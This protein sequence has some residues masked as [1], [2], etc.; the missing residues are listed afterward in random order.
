MNVRN[1]LLVIALHLTLPGFVL[2]QSSPARLSE[3]EVIHGETAVEWPAVAPDVNLLVTVSGPEGLYLRQEQPAGTWAR[4][5]LVNKQ[6]QARPDG[7]YK[8]ELVIQSGW[9]DGGQGTYSGWFEIQGGRVAM[10]GSGE[11]QPVTLEEQAPENSLYI[12]SEGRVGVGTSVPG[13]LLHLK[14]K[15][16]ALAIEDTQAGG[17]EY[18]MRSAI[19]GDGSLGLFDQATGQARWLVDGEGRVGIGTMEPTSTLTVDGYIESTKGFLVNGRPIGGGGF[20]LSG[21]ANPLSG[22]IVGTNSFFGT[23]A[24]ATGSGMQNSFFGYRAGMVNSA[25]GNSF[26]GSDA[27]LANTTGNFNAFFGSMTG[28]SSSTGSEN[29]FF[30]HAAGQLNTTGG[31]NS[32]FGASAGISNT[33]GKNNCFFGLSSGWNNRTGESNSFYGYL[34]GQGNGTGSYNSFYGYSAGE[35]NNASYN[36]FFGSAAGGHNTTGFRNSFFGPYAG[37]SNHTG[38]YNSFFGNQAGY[39]NTGSSNSYF[40]SA[41]GI[42]NST[43]NYGAFFGA[44]S[45]LAN[46][47]GS[48][49]SFFGYTAGLN[50]TSGA[51]NSFFG[52]EAGAAN[53]VESN[54][55]FLGAEANLGPG[56]DPAAHPVTNA[57]AIGY[58][59][60]VSRSN[61]LV[62]GAVNGFNQATTETNVGIGTPNP[63]RQFVVEGSEAIGKLRRYNNLTTSHGPAFLFERARGSIVSPQNI[64]AGDYLGK[65]QFR[66]RVGGNMPEYGALVFIASDTNQN[67]KFAFVDRDLYTERMVIWN[68]GNVGIGTSNPTARLDVAGDLR[69]RGDILQ[70]APTAAVPDYVFAPDYKLMPLARLEQYVKSERHLPDVPSASEIQRQGVNLSKLQM[71]L[72]EKIEE[73][74]LY[75][76]EQAK[77]IQEQQRTIEKL[78]RQQEELVGLKRK[79]DQL[80]ALM[81]GK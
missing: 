5:S 45:G 63:D 58:R 42:A 47:T 35:D 61:S 74:T 80:E 16:P 18:R 38:F 13:A 51:N 26:F 21:G 46:T 36:A 14:G 53:T 11:K 60:Y 31:S 24:G 34:A 40:G 30:G 68:S 41:A 15:L 17:R 55:T 32:F 25:D 1:S 57:T 48:K 76:F 64:I 28:V 44:S 37:Y 29:S 79:L 12:D 75:T 67:G 8:W 9:Q 2:S 3:L 77:Q 69:V 19:S 4:F 6:G 70:G 43:G 10:A 72:L 52:E 54:N 27:G 73:L 50:N 78:E 71:K 56:P 7:I 20:G 23:Q 66:G 39:T 62:L 49:N 33:S 22:T 81:S 59:A 65:F